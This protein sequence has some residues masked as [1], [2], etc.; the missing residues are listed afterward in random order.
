MVNNGCGYTGGQ[1][2]ERI[3]HR[4]GTEIPSQQK[5]GLIRVKYKGFFV[6]VILLSSVKVF[7][8]GS[9]MT[10][11]HPLVVGLEFK[12]GNHR[13][14]FDGIDGPKQFINVNSINNVVSLYVLSCLFHFMILL[15]SW[16]VFYRNLSLRLTAKKA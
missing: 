8:C 9:V 7:D 12:G 2:G 4:I 14:F 15:L 1:G 5:G 6:F 16:F 10:A 11:A 13:S 3:L